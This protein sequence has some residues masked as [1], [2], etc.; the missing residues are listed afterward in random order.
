MTNNVKIKVAVIGAGR[1]G[2]RHANNL[3]AGRI[4]GAV[5]SAVCD[6]DEKALKKYRGNAAVYTDYKELIDTE[7][8][9]AVVVATP[10]YS[11][12]E[13]AVYAI[14][15]GVST[16]VEKPLTVTAKEAKKVIAAA[17]AHPSVTA[18]VMLNQRT[19]PLY[20]R[21]KRLVDNGEIGEIRRVDYI[22]TDWYRSQAYYKQGGWRASYSGEGGGTLINQCVHQ[23]DIVQ[24]ITGMPTEVTAYLNTRDRNITVENEVTAVFGYANGAHCTF[25]ASAAELHGA[26]RLEIAGDKGRIVIDK[27]KM[28]VII[29]HKSE[30]Q[31]NADTKIGYGS[32]TLKYTKKY[33][34]TAVMIKELLTGQQLNILRNFTAAIRGEEHLLSPI[35]DGL[36]SVEMI[37]AAYMSGWQDE[38]TY[39]PVD[40]DI[41]EKL[42]GYKC[43]GEKENTVERGIN[44]D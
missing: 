36:N 10:H 31:V 11:H 34:A 24:W 42:L 26:N 40:D 22:I 28:K 16:L 7:K 30:P 27:Y 38:K 35:A 44:N 9:D 41:Y 6:T 19:N 4:K 8:P 37:N 17:K 1:M 3:L 21:A 43:G 33:D 18:A 23:L 13:I 5:L 12:G 14:N 2:G 29:F 32:V 20:A 15:H 25:T 39:M